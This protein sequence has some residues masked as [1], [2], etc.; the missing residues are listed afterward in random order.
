MMHVDCMRNEHP[1]TCLRIP[2]TGALLLLLC[3]LCAAPAAAQ[4]QPD[5]AERTQ[6]FVQQLDYTHLGMLAVHSEGR[7]KSFG[8]H[9][10]SIMRFISGP[11]EVPLLDSEGVELM[12]LP[13]KFTYLDM[14]LRPNLYDDAPLVFVRSKAVRGE[15][16]DS[17]RASMEIQME[18]MWSADPVIASHKDEGVARYEAN[19]ARFARTGLISP[20]MLQ[21]P[22]VNQALARLK[23]DLVRT[24]RPVDEIES[25]LNSRR[26]GML[27][28]NLRLVPPPGGGFDDQWLTIE[29][30]ATMN[31]ARIDPQ[32]REDITSHWQK[33]Q[34]GWKALD[35]AA[36]NEA[37]ARL[38]A[39]LPRINE[40]IYP[41]QS[42]LA[43]ESWYF[44]SKNMTWVWLIYFAAIIPLLL[45]LVFKWTPA[46]WIGM[47]LFT[48][49]FG[50]HTFAIGLRWYVS[51]RFPN[52]NMFEAV[53]TAAWFGGIVA[54]TLELFVRR[55]P[56]RTLFALGAAAGSATAL[57]VAWAYPVGLDPTIRNMMPVLHDIWLY[58]HTNV[59]ILAYALIFMAAVTAGLYMIYRMARWLGGHDGTREYAT[60]G[61]AASLIMKT[62][63]GRTFIEK[64]RSSLGQVLDGSTMVLMELSFILLWAGLVMGASWADHSWGRPWGWDPKEVFALNTFIVFA[65]LIHVR[66]KIRDKGLWTA[67]ICLIGAG[68][69][70]FNWIAINFVVV[71]LHSYA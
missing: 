57:M 32:L 62:P 45:S 34:N 2:T 16:A 48:V 64:S 29:Q 3:I 42:R 53:T 55:L 33:F 24:A 35:A 38:A 10:A 52:S 41:Q 44:N 9:A 22:G 37:S 65:V 8:S 59:I 30:Y 21:D 6:K 68:V 7:V 4:E 5:R 17:F 63:D 31:D 50:F 20:L 13:H 70:I 25:A 67:I 11:R 40:E 60:M 66:L 61:G 43:W 69:M 58:I 26:P 18:T 47:L 36:V 23:Q 1:S 39:L 49:A 56:L 71:G 54:I 27:R 15:I 14:M 28:S 46:Q 51:G 19:L 12:S